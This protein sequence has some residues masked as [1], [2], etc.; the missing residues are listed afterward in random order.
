MNSKIMKILP[1]V[2]SVNE[3]SKRKSN[4]IPYPVYT[5]LSGSAFLASLTPPNKQ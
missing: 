1:M 4:A 2:P 3:K 5:Y